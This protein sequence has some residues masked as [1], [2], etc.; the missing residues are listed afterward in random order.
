MRV[1]SRGQ[2]KKQIRMQCSVYAE[3][4]ARLAVFFLSQTKDL[5]NYA[6]CV[7]EIVKITSLRGKKYG[8]LH[9][10]QH[11]VNIVK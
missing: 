6:F 3:D 8:C 10:L 5:I 1:K 4:S 9:I 7:H 11:S 2:K